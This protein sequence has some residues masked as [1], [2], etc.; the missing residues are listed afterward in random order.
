[1]CPRAHNCRGCAPKSVRR[2]K[3]T[4]LPPRLDC[5]SRRSNPR[6]GKPSSK[7]DVIAPGVRRQPLS[8]SPAVPLK[9]GAEEAAASNPL[10]FLKSNYPTIVLKAPVS[11]CTC[12]D[13]GWTAGFV[14]RNVE[15]LRA[16]FWVT[17]APGGNAASPT[18]AQYLT[19][20]RAVARQAPPQTRSFTPLRISAR[21][22][23]RFGW[24]ALWSS[25]FRQGKG[26]GSRF[27]SSSREWEGGVPLGS[28]ETLERCRRDA[29][30]GDGEGA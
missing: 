18:W 28:G 23:A 14:P 13:S 26:P 29:S 17:C 5:R 12:T 2:P 27:L 7:G 24:G 25:G 8:A 6:E 30:S 3:L 10:F 21:L 9:L 20:G 19:A 4:P 1:M 11:F 16:V 22:P 15:T